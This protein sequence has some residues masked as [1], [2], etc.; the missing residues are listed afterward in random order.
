MV[1]S[2][3]SEA[4]HE[5]RLSRTWGTLVRAST[6]ARDFCSNPPRTACLYPAPKRACRLAYPGTLQSPARFL[7]SWSMRFTADSA[8][9]YGRRP[10]EAMAPT[11][12]CL[13]AQLAILLLAR[14]HSVFAE[15][16]A[17]AAFTARRPPMS[18]PPGGFADS[19]AA[20]PSFLPPHGV[21]C[22]AWVFG[23]RPR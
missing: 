22:A 13:R 19:V 20:S 6:A 14:R 16:M 4:E 23:G 15:L 21:Y 11:S 7:D 3:G 2:T 8:L 5:L 9:D 1:L 18:Q 12:C 10:A 17:C